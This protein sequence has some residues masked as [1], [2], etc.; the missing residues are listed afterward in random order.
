[1]SPAFWPVTALLH[2]GVFLRVFVEPSV[3]YP[4]LL[5]PD[6]SEAVEAPAQEEFHELGEARLM[7]EPHFIRKLGRFPQLLLH[8]PGHLY[9]QVVRFWRLSYRDPGLAVLV[10]F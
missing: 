6:V 7:R 4:H 3:I 10:A 2:L 9:V 5:G 1:M 8:F